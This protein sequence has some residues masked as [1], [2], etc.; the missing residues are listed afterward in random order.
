MS[1]EV[2][3]RRL[4]YEERAAKL[5]AEAA[6]ARRKGE[7]KRKLDAKRA[8]PV[9]GKLRAALGNLYGAREEACRLDEAGYKAA[10]FEELGRS[11]G[12]LEASITA[13]GVPIPMPR[14]TSVA[15]KE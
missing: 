13:Y 11:I 10:F 14:A 15:A 8:T 2:K 12:A 6:E 4:T 3:T 5:E 9:Y 1:E 7:E